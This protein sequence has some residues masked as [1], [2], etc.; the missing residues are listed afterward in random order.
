MI[1]DV[2]RAA[3]YADDTGEMWHELVEITASGLAEP[4]RGVNAR[5]EGFTLVNGGQTYIAYPFELTW[6]A[7][8]A[9]QP[10]QGAR[11]VINNVVA[12]DGSDE[13][14][15]LNGLRQLNERARV[16]FKLVR[17]SA[18]DVVEAQ[19][20]RLRLTNI[21]YDAMTI[22]GTLEL[23]DFNGRRA[24]YRFTPD[25]YPNLRPA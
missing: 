3:L 4:I 22:S 21:Q 20:T 5:E 1:T 13:P 6:P 7:R 23:P 9:T 17:R 10:F 24:G 19:T 25:R 14:V 18:P 2:S 12:T 11:M 8:D 15:A 16:R